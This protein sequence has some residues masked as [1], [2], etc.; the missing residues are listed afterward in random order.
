MGSGHV[1]LHGWALSYDSFWTLDAP[2]YALASVIVGIRPSLLFAVPAIIATAVIVFG[3][4]MAR[5]GRRGAAAVAG[6]LTVVALLA[7]PTH[8]FASFF[9]RGPFHV[10][11]ALFSLFAFAG[12]RRPRWGWGWAVSVVFLTLGMLGDLQILFYGVA[13]I[14]LAGIATMMRE[15]KLRN[16]IIMSSA[17]IAALPLTVISRKTFEFFGAFTIGPANPLASFHQ[18]L[19][20]V[21]HS[22][23][24]SLELIGASSS[25]LGTGGVPG[26]L[27][28]VHIVPALLMAACLVLELV[29]LVRGVVGVLQRPNPLPASV[30]PAGT[31]ASES[32]RNGVSLTTPRYSRLRMSV[33]SESEGESWRIDYMLLIATAGSC[34][35]FVFLSVTNDF[36]YS[37][38]LVT[39]VIFAAILTGRLVGRYWSQFVR[40][41][42]SRLVTAL[43][44]AATVLIISCVGFTLAQP[45]PAQPAAELGSWLQANH[46]TNGVGDYWSASIVT[47]DTKNQVK[48]RPVVI[49]DDGSLVRF[50]RES[51]ASWYESRTF[52]FFVYNLAMPWGSD[53]ATTATKTWGVPA[54]T[55]IVGTY[56]IL[57]WN[58]PIVVQ[59]P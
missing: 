20:N 55:F 32:A 34:A 25:H 24:Y 5:E 1:L 6:S 4:I 40:S 51:A 36:E 38:Y 39:G 8:A 41:G 48:V 31:P 3:A 17:A 45:V 50:M 30:P 57:T 47:V 33:S 14:F 19:I 58:A 27:Q 59:A 26:A 23:T 2:F 11:T 13:P 12:L 37:R 43:G 9:V 46:L 28:M 56:R 49:G 10:A 35:S 22:G 42:I 18:M 52:Q 44:I 53:N 7:F 21:T 15:R 16:G 29:F 54:H